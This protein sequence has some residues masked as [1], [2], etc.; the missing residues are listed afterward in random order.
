MELVYLGS[1]SKETKGV[2]TQLCQLDSV[3]APFRYAVEIDEE[4]DFG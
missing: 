4:Q 2:S 1:A 3:K